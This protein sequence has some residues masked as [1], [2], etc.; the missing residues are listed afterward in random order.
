MKMILDLDTGIDDTLALAC[1][2]GTPRIDLIGVVC[3]YGNVE[4]GQAVKNTLKVLSLFGREDIP[5]IRGARAPLEKD[6]FE[7]RP[8][9]R[10]VHG[11]DGIGDTG[12]PDVDRSAAGGTAEDF[13]YDMAV[14]HGPDLVIVTEGPLTNLAA[15]IRKYPDLEKTGVRVVTMG[16]A[17]CVEGN[18]TPV[19]E[20]NLFQDA[21][22]HMCP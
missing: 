7:V 21:L 22:A 12:L 10:V 14:A 16:G 5:V 6:V 11:V 2:L 1:V 17:V 4:V 3:S 8:L 13:F 20:S 15:A 9:S 18:M 19:G